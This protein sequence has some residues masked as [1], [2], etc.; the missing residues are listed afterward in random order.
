[1]AMIPEQQ[2]DNLIRSSMFTFGSS[3]KSHGYR[4][5]VKEEE[6]HVGKFDI[7]I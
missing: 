2:L 7:Y 4:R 3:W 5:I 6:N 1:M